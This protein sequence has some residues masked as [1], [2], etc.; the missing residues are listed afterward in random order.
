[1]SGCGVEAQRGP[2]QSCGTEAIAQIP[3]MRNIREKLLLKTPEM[4]SNVISPTGAVLY[5]CVLL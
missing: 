5:T 2:R 4:F 1:M 3:Q